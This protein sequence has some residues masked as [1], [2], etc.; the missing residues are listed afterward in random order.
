MNV[1]SGYQND[2]INFIFQKPGSTLAI[3]QHPDVQRSIDI[4]RNNLFENAARALAITFPTVESLMGRKAFRFLVAKLLQTESKT[5]FDWGEYGVGFPAV[6]AEQEDLIEFPYLSEVAEYDWL[7]HQTQRD[8]DIFA[9]PTSFALLQE[10]DLSTLSFV[11]STGFTVR[12]FWFPVIE[13][14]Q[15]ANNHSLT[16][17]E[18]DELQKS[19]TKLIKNAINQDKPRSL[20]MWRPDY[21]AKAEWLEDQSLSAFILL[22]KQASTADIIAEVEAQGLDLTQW[23]SQII[24]SKKVIGIKQQS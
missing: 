23:L 13:L 17:E 9:N 19:T 5:H 18:K 12:E 7:V 2:L 21:K 3:E 11:T 24:E 14:H 4:Y 8:A 22:M 20:V 6:I 15:L 1:N 10:Q 16:S